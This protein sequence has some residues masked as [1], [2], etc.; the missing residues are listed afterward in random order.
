MGRRELQKTGCCPDDN[1]DGCLKCKDN[2]CNVYAYCISCCLQPKHPIQPNFS[3]PE[4]NIDKFDYCRGVCRTNS[5][6][7]V[8]ENQWKSDLKYCF[9]YQNYYISSQSISLEEDDGDNSMG[10]FISEQMV[11]DL[12]EN[13]RLEG[14]EL[15]DKGI[16]KESGGGKTNEK[17]EKVV[18]ND[19]ENDV[20][21][22][23][24]LLEKV[25]EKMRKLVEENEHLTEENQNLVKEI[26]ILA[27]KLEKLEEQKGKG[28]IESTRERREHSNGSGR[29]ITNGLLVLFLLILGYVYMGV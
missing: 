8:N 7:V 22:I 27:D 29:V 15:G 10:K 13:T 24:N 5:R 26:K 11:G 2:C 28:L 4:M 19:P 1:T 12:K 17:S 21:V 20:D 23:E 3:N 14:E 6:S 16:M 25:D 18:E 9:P